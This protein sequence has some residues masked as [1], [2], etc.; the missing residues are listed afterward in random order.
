MKAY[1]LSHTQSWYEHRAEKVV[2]NED[3]KVLRDFNVF[4]D[5]FIEAR[6]PDII[7]VKKKVKE[8]VV[9]DIAVH[10][11]VRTKIKGEEKIDKYQ[12]LLERF[13]D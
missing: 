4:V 11:D 8:C 9:I 5:K 13:L 2:E 10:G 6:R 1:G 3:V 7:M 12:D